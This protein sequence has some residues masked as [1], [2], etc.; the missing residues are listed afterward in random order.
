MMSKLSL[1]PKNA[2]GFSA[3]LKYRRNGL[4]WSFTP[5]FVYKEDDEDEKEEHTNGNDSRKPV[6]QSLLCF[7]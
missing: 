3:V 4:P 5:G 7:L 2:A 1:Y 6:G